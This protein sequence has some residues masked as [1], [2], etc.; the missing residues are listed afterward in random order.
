MPCLSGEEPG[1]LSTSLWVV[2]VQVMFALTQE[3]KKPQNRRII[4]VGRGN[5]VVCSPAQNRSSLDHISQDLVPLSRESLQA[6]GSGDFSEP[7]FL[8]LQ[9][10]E[11]L[12]PVAVGHRLFLQETPELW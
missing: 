3:E 11:C 7:E 5:L 10:S 1:L 6:Q 4:V 12:S 9:R 2:F 8:W